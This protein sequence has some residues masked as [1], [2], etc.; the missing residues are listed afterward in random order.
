M[1]VVRYCLTFTTYLFMY[2]DVLCILG[3]ALLSV[4]AHSALLYLYI[5]AQVGIYTYIYIL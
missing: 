3:T 5:T 1:F 2:A 4:D